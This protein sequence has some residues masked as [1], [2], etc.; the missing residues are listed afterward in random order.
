MNSEPAATRA[1]LL[2]SSTRL[3]A[4]RG[5]RRRQAGRADDGG[6]D[7]VATRVGGRIRQRLGAHP[8]LGKAGPAG[9][10]S[11]NCRRAASSGTTTTS[12]RL[13]SACSASFCM[14]VYADS[15]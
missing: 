6:H 11:R 7:R 2:A 13:A 14:R 3:P 5:Q 15:A 8:D 10:A 4:R 12:A 1:S 9:Q